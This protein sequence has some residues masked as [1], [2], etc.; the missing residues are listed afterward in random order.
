MDAPRAERQPLRRAVSCG[1]VL[2]RYAYDGVLEF[3]L[4]GRRRPPLWA[5][6]KGTP[7]M[8]ETIEQ[9]A[10]REVEEETGVRGRIVAPLGT[11]TYTFRAPRRPASVTG[12][13][14][15]EKT[16]HHFLM[17]PVAGDPA[18]HDAEYDFARWVPI[19]DALA[20]LSHDNERTI[21]RRAIEVVS[22]SVPS[23]KS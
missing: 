22:Q 14:R 3:L 13:T 9:T 18:L 5:L 21:L 10:L 2:F 19:G 11:I 6:P 17:Q 8:D 7:K 20:L 1:G 15:Y 23:P 16:V 4:V 12:G